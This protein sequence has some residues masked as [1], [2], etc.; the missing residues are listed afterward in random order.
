MC[1]RFTLTTDVEDLA[2]LFGAERYPEEL[3][4]SYNIALGSPVAA[5]VGNIEGSGNTG[6]TVRDISHFEWGL[7]PSW[8]KDTGMGRKLINARSET[9]HE[10]PSFRSAFRKRRC[11]IPADGFYEWMKTPDGKRP[12]YIGL[13]D[14]TPFAFAGLWESWPGNEE[15]EGK[16]TCTILTTEANA[17]MKRIHNRMPVILDEES[18]AAWLD[19]DFDDTDALRDMLRPYTP[20]A[21]ETYEVS[22]IVN[23]PANNTEKCVEPVLG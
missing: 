2:A 5:I 13:G 21:M 20:S 10:K 9:A 7:V 23:S 11:L 18:Y 8:A 3:V 19:P 17:L 1:G 14:G 4:P 6:R 15:E 22:R 12:H 16:L